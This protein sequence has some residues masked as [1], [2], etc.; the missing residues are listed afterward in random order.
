MN[1]SH[2]VL[3]QYYF[4][5]ILPQNLGLLEQIPAL[6]LACSVNLPTSFSYP[7][8]RKFYIRGSP[9]HLSRGDGP[10]AWCCPAG[11][12]NNVI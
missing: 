5:F 10:S 6:P 4:L 12:A 9:E 8:S 7:A 3:D 11:L 1:Q 2:K